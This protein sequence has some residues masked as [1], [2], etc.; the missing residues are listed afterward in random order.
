MQALPPLEGWGLLVVG[1]AALA[2]VAWHEFGV[3]RMLT[4]WWNRLDGY[5]DDY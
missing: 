4:E 3:G 5:E 2:M 1:A